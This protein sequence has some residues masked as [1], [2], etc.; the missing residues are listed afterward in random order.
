M[1]IVR[2][3]PLIQPDE[4]GSMFE[5]FMPQRGNF[6]PALDVYQDK[7]N[8]IVETPLVGIDP[9]KINISVENDVLTIEGN[10]EKKTEVDDKKYYRKEIRTGS[11][12][13]AVALP[14]AVNGEKAEAS[15]AE[16]VLKIVIPKEERAKKK[17]IKVQV[18]GKK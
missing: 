18:K 12:H 17:T 9:D 4:F 13:R 6:I 5:D 1:S 10:T 15:Y 14:T 16:G 7:N 2:W 3:R 8:V 11:F